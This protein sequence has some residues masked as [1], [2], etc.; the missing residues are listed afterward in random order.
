MAEL[1]SLLFVAELPGHP[2][3]AVVTWTI[4]GGTADTWVEWTDG[5]GEWS[6]AYVADLTF[7]GR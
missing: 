5:D 3:A 6:R 1:R 2:L 4:E 7:V